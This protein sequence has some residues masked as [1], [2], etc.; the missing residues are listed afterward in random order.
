MEAKKIE[1]IEQ[2]EIE[3]GH[4]RQELI[5]APGAKR[6]VSGAQKYQ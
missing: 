4:L 2:W 5:R 1:A 6:R 3:R